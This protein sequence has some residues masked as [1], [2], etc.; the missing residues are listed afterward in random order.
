MN[1]TIILGISLG[2]LT[3]MN[4]L[5]VFLLLSDLKRHAEEKKDLMNRLMS[6]DFTDFASNTHKIDPGVMDLKKKITKK[7][8][9]PQYETGPGFEEAK[10]Y[11]GEP[12]EVTVI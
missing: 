9:K 5:L 10:N 8:K 1:L 3:A 7:Q 12:D 11:P 2:A 4:F 6:R